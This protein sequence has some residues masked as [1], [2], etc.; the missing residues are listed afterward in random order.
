ARERR[1]LAQRL[2]VAALA[3]M[4]TGDTHSSGLGGATPEGAVRP[5]LR[6]LRRADRSAGPPLQTAGARAR[7]EGRSAL[8]PPRLL[9]GVIRRRRGRMIIGIDHVQITIPA[10]AVA[11]ARA[12]YCGLLGLREV[13]KPAALRGWGGFWLQAGDRQVHV[14]T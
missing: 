12:F 7:F 4:P 9:G 11:E 5:G 1:C 6:T 8:M 13:E 10:N 2:P 14:G 3:V